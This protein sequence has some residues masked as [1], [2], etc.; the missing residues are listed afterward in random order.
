MVAGLECVKGGQ[1]RA[2]SSGPMDSA[3]A[4]S[5]LQAK[6]MLEEWEADNARFAALAKPVPG[7]M[8]AAEPQVVKANGALSH[9]S[10]LPASEEG[11]NGK[12]KQHDGGLAA[13]QKAL[14]ASRKF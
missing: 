14:G 8:D 10:G 7:S 13:K 11:E 5:V 6:D 9:G 1:E 12:L 4:E 3:V 2:E